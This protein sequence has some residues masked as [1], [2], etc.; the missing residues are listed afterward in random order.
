MTLF[1]PYYGINA[2]PS[3]SASRRSRLRDLEARM[4]SFLVEKE[5]SHGVCTRV[6]GNVKECKSR[7]RGEL[8]HLK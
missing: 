3:G 6:L 5:N 2:L 7:L 1:W 8:A 4:D